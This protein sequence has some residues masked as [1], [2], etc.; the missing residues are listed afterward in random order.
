MLSSADSY[1]AH[2]QKKGNGGWREERRE[3]EHVGQNE[4]VREI[5]RE[6]ESARERGIMGQRQSLRRNNQ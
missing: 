2:M 6:R 4:R 3:E 1:A 5:A